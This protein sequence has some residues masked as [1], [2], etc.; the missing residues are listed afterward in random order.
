VLVTHHVDEI[1]PGFTH[2][3]LLREG[4]AVAKG[5][6]AKALTTA[7]LSVCFGLDLVLEQRG[8]RYS[9]WATT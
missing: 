1:P 3:L 6:I 9:A 7:N 4:R 5:P 8:D 2:A